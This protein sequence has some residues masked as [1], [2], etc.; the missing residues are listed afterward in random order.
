MWG[1]R[2]ARRARPLP[3]AF[4]LMYHCEGK[5]R[6]GPDLFL[7]SASPRP[8]PLSPLSSPPPRLTSPDLTPI[9]QVPVD[10]SFLASSLE[11][12][13]RTQPSKPGGG[14]PRAKGGEKAAR[15]AGA[16]AGWSSGAETELQDEEDEP[17]RRAAPPAGG[18]PSSSSSSRP[19]TLAE[20]QVAPRPR[21][22]LASA[23]APLR[24]DLAAISL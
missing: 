8:A 17:P 10:R 16:E 13:M 1:F 9:S 19:K 24:I 12:R 15:R 6:P 23:L 4:V 2:R 22:D 18:G 20:Q 3:P 14:P 5:A 11:K 7:T 21:V